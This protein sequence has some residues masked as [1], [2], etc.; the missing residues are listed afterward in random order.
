MSHLAFRTEKKTINDFFSTPLS[1]SKSE[2]KEYI[3]V[4]LYYKFVSIELAPNF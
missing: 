1:T 2:I 3:L 4:K